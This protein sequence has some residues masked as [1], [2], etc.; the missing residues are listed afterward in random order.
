MSN[1][2]IVASIEQLQNSLNNKFEDTMQIVSSSS[3]IRQ[4]LITPLKLDPNKNYK[5]G[6]KYFATFNNIRNITNE[7][8]ELKYSINNTQNTLT[9]EQGAYEIKDLNDFIQQKLPNFKDSHSIPYSI[10]ADL[11]HSE[12]DIRN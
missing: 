4:K 8:N 10:Y 12:C 1:E 9:I 3:D 2:A 5:I 6:V 7:N 11:K